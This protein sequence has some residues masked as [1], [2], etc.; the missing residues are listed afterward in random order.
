M[1]ILKSFYELSLPKYSYINR[2]ALLEANSN[3]I[4]IVSPPKCGK[5]SL[6]LEISK[7]F[8]K[9][10]I[11]YL[12]L[13]DLRIQNQNLQEL[14]EFIAIN[15]IKALFLDDFDDSFVIPQCE[16]IFISTLIPL[17][18][19]GFETIFL[20]ALDFEEYLIFEKKFT[21]LESSLNNF[22]KNG[23]L[24]SITS[25]SQIDKNQTKQEI[26]RLI[27]SD[28]SELFILSHLLRN[29]GNKFTLFQHYNLIKKE[30]KISKDRYYAYANE[31]ALKRIIHF[32]EKLNQPNSAKKIYAFDFSLKSAITFERNIIKTFENMLFL[33][34]SK[35]DFEIYYLDFI[36]FIIPENSI[37]IISAP[38][39]NSSFVDLK[40]EKILES[41]TIVE[42]KKIIFVT[43]SF[44]ME[45]VVKSGVEIEV[46]P[47]FR[48]AL[49]S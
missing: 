34:I 5:T 49:S 43:I 20:E 2:K 40:I 44:E 30:I 35:S 24:P 4:L 12:P 26:L 31:L 41:D 39:A 22:I 17:D 46:L 15:E 47:F 11:L 14:D 25:I 18:F 1:D 33:E 23:N 8:K 16:N 3:K 7:R 38:F 21:N 6:L 9:D 19:D 37:G 27:T 42:I 29:V 10:R 48:F 13:K 32:L 45:S 28:K 36:D